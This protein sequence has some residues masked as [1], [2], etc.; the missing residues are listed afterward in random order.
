MTQQPQTA[1]HTFLSVPGFYV[2][3]H[4]GVNSHAGLSNHLLYYLSVSLS[5]PSN[6]LCLATQLAAC[7]AG[8]TL[9]GWIYGSLGGGDE[10]VAGVADVLQSGDGMMNE[11]M[12]KRGLITETDGKDHSGISRVIFFFFLNFLPSF[13]LSFSQARHFAITNR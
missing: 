2:T 9:L 8:Q 3:W 11:V 1:L 4:L 5:L 12:K 13:P 10:V 6:R 7:P